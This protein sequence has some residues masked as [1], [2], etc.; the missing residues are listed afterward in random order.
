KVASVDTRPY[1]NK[2]Y[3]P[4]IT[5]SLQQEANRKLGMTAKRTMSAAQSLYEKGH[6]TYMRTDS[7][8][9]AKEAVTSARD[10]I[11]SH[12]G[13]AY[14]P[15][16]PRN[17]EHI[18]KVKNAQ[19]AHEAIRPSGDQLSLPETLRPT[20][21]QDE[22]R[23]YDLIWKRTI[24]SEMENSRGRH[25]TIVI[26]GG[27]TIFQV[28]GKTI[29]FPGY[30]RAY[31]EGADDPTASL[32]D[33]ETLLPSV[34]E[35][36]SLDCKEMTPQ[37]H[38]T[39]PPA[40]FTEASLTKK[41]EQLGIGRPSTYASTIE[42]I[43]NREYV[44]KKNNALVPTWTAFAVIKLLEQHLADLVDYQFTAKME[45]ELDAISRGDSGYVKYLKGFYFGNG[46]PG[47]KKLLENK[48]E[49]ID[50]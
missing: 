28:K 34:E 18:K 24:A 15:A 36:E 16:K 38:T 8:Q 22:F 4:F 5:S 40:R 44:F 12:Y 10:L 23:L 17:S 21:N 27:G 46:G 37:S 2:P 9:L 1:S 3:P 33:Q 49:E 39:Q 47:L 35:G 11:K 29:D 43:L 25:I 31:V 13:D 42:T 6:I 48:L 45:D 50:A 7:M 41:L 30:L 32:A 14:L 26:E 19:E 20:L